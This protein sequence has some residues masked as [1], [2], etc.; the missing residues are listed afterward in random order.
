M[1]AKSYATKVNGEI[2]TPQTGVVLWCKDNVGVI[3]GFNN[4]AYLFSGIYIPKTRVRF[5][6]VNNNGTLIAFEIERD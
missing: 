3:K 4:L 1:T 2:L 5:N 6:P